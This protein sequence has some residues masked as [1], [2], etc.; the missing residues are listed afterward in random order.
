M[1]ERKDLIL[2]LPEKI[3]AIIKLFKERTGISYTNFIYN[4]IVWFCISKGLLSLD[5]L[6]IAS[7]EKKR[8]F[9][10]FTAEQLAQIEANKFCDG[11]SCEIDYSKGGKC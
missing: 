5:Y 11:D 1:S 2:R 4:A 6:K 8:I 7:P 3:F 10:K 9:T